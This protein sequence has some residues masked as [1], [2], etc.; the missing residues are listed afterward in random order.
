M[1]DD[2]S[3]GLQREAFV[4]GA[5]VAMDFMTKAFRKSAK[6]GFL[7]TFG[8]EPFEGHQIS[9]DWK[10]GNQANTSVIPAHMAAVSPAIAAINPPGPRM[11]WL[12]GED[13]EDDVSQ[14][15]P[16]AAEA[17]DGTGV[18]DFEGADNR[19]RHSIADLDDDDDDPLWYSSI[20]VGHG[21]GN[22]YFC[23]EMGRDVWLCP[24]LFKYFPTA[25]PKLYARADEIPGGVTPTPMAPS[26]KW[27]GGDVLGAST[28]RRNHSTP[29]TPIN[30]GFRNFREYFGF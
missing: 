12:A 7:L 24:A 14:D 3:T 1:F 18:P 20:Q 29:N 19:H 10:V 27:L 9:L 8:V 25:P 16:H 21:F 15:T 22:T 13:D 11:S 26:I 5:D 17:D 23:P 2:E 6:H 4:T 30:H 28:R